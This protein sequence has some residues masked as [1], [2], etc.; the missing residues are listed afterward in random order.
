MPD[1]S[2][3]CLGAEPTPL[4]ADPKIT[5]RLKIT[6]QV[7]DEPI[8]TV[9]LRCQLRIEPTQRHYTP[10]EKEQ[11]YDLFDEPSR[12]GHTLRSMSWAHCNVTVPAFTDEIEVEMPVPC[13][14]DFNI[15]TTK[16]FHG[17]TTGEVPIN[18]LF[19]GTVFYQAPPTGMMV[20]QIPWEKETS[21]R[22]PVSVWRAMMDQYY[23]NT[24]WLCLRKDIFEQLSEYKR[25]HSIP[26]WERAIQQLLE[27]QNRG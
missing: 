16:Y 19:S 23:P 20:A 13:T 4:S 15:G 26:T 6:N 2:F 25:Q 5:F 17:L 1:L 3:E 10:E 8:F 27:S 22:L 18:L 21:Y 7:K 12:W 9:T 11:L 14:Y 24:A